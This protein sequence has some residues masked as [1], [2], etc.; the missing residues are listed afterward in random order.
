M[1]KKSTDVTPKK[2]DGKVT[3]DIITVSKEK[4]NINHVQMKSQSPKRELTSDNSI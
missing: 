1:K 2:A 3:V 4:E